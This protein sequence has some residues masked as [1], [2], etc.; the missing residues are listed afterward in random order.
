MF[1]AYEPRFKK[2]LL[3]YDS[4][5]SKLLKRGIAS[6]SYP[7]KLSS[8]L[9]S[10]LVRLQDVGFPPRVLCNVAESL[11]KKKRKG[12]EEES[13]LGGRGER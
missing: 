10:Q 9:G 8:G 1:W 7:H 13:R 6:K 12:M 3:P 11:E 4:A 5:H 2:K